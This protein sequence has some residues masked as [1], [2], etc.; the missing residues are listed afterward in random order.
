MDE[1]GDGKKAHA[2][3]S[4]S[5]GEFGHHCGKQV[6]TQVFSSDTARPWQPRQMTWEVAPSKLPAPGAPCSAH[7]QIVDLSVM[8]CAA[9]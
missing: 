7:G 8:G 9:H 5:L 4:C 3:E 1:A 2:V 6:L